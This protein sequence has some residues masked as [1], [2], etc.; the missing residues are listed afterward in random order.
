ML[1]TTPMT[2]TG[3][4]LGTATTISTNHWLMAWI[5]LET[6]MLAILMV[7]AKP[8]T[9]RA[10]E[11]T[12]KYFLMQ[13]IASIMILFSSTTNAWQMGTWDITQ[14]YNKYSSTIMAV[15]LATKL[16]AAPIHFW[17]PEVMQGSS[18][19]TALL[20]S[21]WQKIAPMTL[22]YMAAKNMQPVIL[23]TIGLMSML[24][25]GLGGINQTQLR[26]TMAYSS[27]NNT[28]WTLLIMPISPNI[29]MLNMF[30]YM[31][32]TIPTF[33]IMMKSST[34]TLRDLTGMWTTSPIFPHMMALLMLSTSGLPPLTGFIPKLM[35]LNELLQQKMVTMA[36]IAAL[37]SLLSLVFYLRIT[38]LSMMLTPPTT[39]SASM[40]WRHT[41]YQP[42]LT[43]CLIPT[44]LTTLLIAPAIP[45]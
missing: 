34:K 1:T 8:K 32:T 11:A 29:A 40:K 31:N 14:L 21:T 27:I 22:M 3:I 9:T 35:I 38:Y 45:L 5:G 15:A 20:L 43:S 7:I 13:A 39:S 16:G 37:M 12:T 28:G 4:F 24:I 42:A 25:G 41:N 17:L 33:L 23:T 2:T 10:T 26:K 18:L 30:I 19:M 36:T 44:A 6:N